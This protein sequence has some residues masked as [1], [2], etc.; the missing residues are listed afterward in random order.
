MMQYRHNRQYSALSLL[1]TLIALIYVSS[2]HAQNS[3][4][5]RFDIPLQPISTALTLF[6]EQ[7][8]IQIL[9]KANQVSKTKTVE[10][11]GRYS[12]QQALKKLLKNTQL[13]YQFGNSHVVVIY[14]QKEATT[15]SNATLP[16]N[17]PTTYPLAHHSSKRLTEELFV[18]G[19]RN[20][21]ISSLD[22]KKS[23]NNFS[24]VITNEDIGKFP[25]K[26]IADSLQ[27]VA[28]VSVDRIWGEGRDIN[29]RGTDKD[30]N[31]TLLNG[32]NVASAYW[33]ANDNPSRGF[34]YSILA[35]ELVSSVEIHKSPKADLDEG[36][37]G[38]TVYLNT[39]APLELPSREGRITLESQY[40]ELPEKLDP[41]A[42][43]L[44][45]W[46]NNEA[47]FGV[48][49]SITYQKRHVRR[50]GLEAFPR[51]QMYQI[52]D[53]DNLVYDDVS[54]PW[55]T[56]SAIFKQVRERTTGHFSTQWQPKPNWDLKINGI[57]SQMGMNNSNHNYLALF[58]VDSLAETAP[59]TVKNPIIYESTS[60]KKTLV[61]GT[62]G[63][64]T[65]LLPTLDAIFRD[66]K[67][68]TQ[69][70]DL[71]LHY[72]RNSWK[73]HTQIGTTA[74]E[75]GSEHDY[76]F[77][78]A[79]RS[80]V[81]YEFKNNSI[82]MNFL[83]IDPRSASA[84]NTFSDQSRDWVRKMQ[85][86]EIFGQ[87]DWEHNF[88]ANVLKK[89]KTGF[90]LRKREINN[91]RIKGSINTHSEKWQDLKSFG[92]QYVSREVS[93]RLHNETA[94]EGSLQQYA[95]VDF[96]LASEQL[97]PQLSDDVFIYQE[98][99]S[100][101]YNIKEGISAGYILSYWG[102]GSL[103]SNLGIRW[104]STDQVSSFFDREDSSVS[105]KRNYINILPSLNI[106]YYFSDRLLSRFS[107]A[108]VMA[109]PSFSN[110]SGNII[111]DGQEN[112]ASSGNPNLSPFKANQFDLGVEWYFKTASLAA[113]N[114]FYKE[115]STFLVAKSENELI[116]GQI[117]SVSRPLNAQP[118]DM[119]GVELQ[120]QQDL[121]NNV[122][123]IANYTFTNTNSSEYSGIDQVNLPGNSRDQFNSSL[124]Y[125]NKPWSAR[126]SYNYRSKSFGGFTDGSQNLT[127]AYDQWDISCKWL[128][129]ERIGLYFE[130]INLGNEIVSYTSASGIPQGYYEN[131]RRFTLGIR[132]TTW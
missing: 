1:I 48:L 45:N 68:K 58:D 78:F 128:I 26:N 41:Q 19:F 81:D 38:G 104:V 23:N 121:W 103:E 60:G 117:Y 12:T 105:H 64:S 85:D 129:G 69:F 62:L 36:S 72:S 95:I 67:I 66:A 107:A 55:A 89:I 108:K 110:L 102:M 71:D 126:L 57:F 22:I 56:G 96:D 44:I 9:F 49:T 54:I 3:D 32:Q 40:N 76:L 100:A 109:R 82:A 84:L 18:T 37:I 65:T 97:I 17:E 92:L 112:N 98:D 39:R 11:Y 132:L 28:G 7:A 34:N 115:L 111:V 94:I 75:G 106:K 50:D 31:R 24:D 10:L 87:L 74:A 93:P 118:L 42:A 130:G 15:T 63:S 47:N 27:R 2:S 125:E 46:Q 99:K 33:W 30:V 101:F 53:Q 113:A 8:D 29:I 4:K 120:W 90:K 13:K 25:D 116:D 6:A 88:N 5:I 114:L 35:S 51:D 59:I 52:Q 86:R 20:S 77:R 43:M 119:W 127:K 70:Y 79:G 124:Y 14:I 21:L 61:G 73:L 91:K 16:K 83:D 80:A 131:G 122:G 123:I